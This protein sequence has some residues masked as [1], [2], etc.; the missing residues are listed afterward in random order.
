MSNTKTINALLIA[1]LL[2]GSASVHASVAASA[3][4][5]A[6]YD[7]GIKAASESNRPLLIEFYTDW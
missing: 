6:T 2:A 3:P 7:E 1:G 4:H 5:F